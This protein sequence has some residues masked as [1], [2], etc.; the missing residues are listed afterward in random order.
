MVLTIMRHVP[1]LFGRRSR[2]ATEVPS[3]GRAKT[4]ICAFIDETVIAIE[5]K[6]TNQRRAIG[7][8]ALNRYYA[9]RSYIAVLDRYVTSTLVAEATNWDLG[10]LSLSATGV[11]IALPA[12]QLTPHPELRTRMICSLER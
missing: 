3:H 4:D 5:A 11:E 9:D 7:Q 1:R 12:P 10:I 8:A 6:L 2:R